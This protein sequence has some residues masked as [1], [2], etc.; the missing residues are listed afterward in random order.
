[1]NITYVIRVNDFYRLLL[2]LGFSL[3]PEKISVGKGY[4]A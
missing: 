2:D 4:G 3:E 1:M